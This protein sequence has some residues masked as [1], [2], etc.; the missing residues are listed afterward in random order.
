MNLLLCIA[1][2]TPAL[3]KESTE[4]ALSRAHGP[5][6]VRG[7][8]NGVELEAS[9]I[10]AAG[11]LG[12]GDATT[13]DL[14]HS[15]TNLGVPAALHALVGEGAPDDI[16]AYIHDDVHILEDGWDTRVKKTFID[17]PNCG[18]AGF[19]GGT[20]IGV[21]AIYTIPYD[22]R[23]V[24]RHNFYSNMVNAELHGRRVTQEMRIASTDGFSMILKRELLTKAGGW[25]WWP[26]DIVHHGY[27]IGIGCMARRHGYEG[28]LVPCLV[29]HKGS[30]TYAQATYSNLAKTL[31]GDTA[32]HAA[33][34]KFVYD[35]FRDVLPFTV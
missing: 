25:A 30:R 20:G 32:I 31:G 26:F 23:Q 5:I 2:A 34:H 22:L 13:V 9:C 15:P 6:H 21:G 14:L 24:G 17:H 35:T 1:S 8:G 7:F 4:H 16:L 10:F 12:G 33:S 3:F 19:G 18:L 27:D 29:D 28:W 11:S